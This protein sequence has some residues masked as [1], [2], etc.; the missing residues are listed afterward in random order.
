MPPLPS[1]VRLGVASDQM[2]TI[3]LNDAIRRALEGNNQIEVS[4][5]NVRLAEATLDSL[6]GIYQPVFTITPQI[7]NQAQPLTNVSDVAVGGNLTS[8]STTS[9]TIA[10]GVSKQFRR[11][12]GRYDFSFN[13][14]R[15]T[16]NFNSLSTSYN[17]GFGVNLTQPLLRDRAIDS[18]RRDIRIQRKRLEQ[19]DADFRLQVI[20]IIAQVQNAYWELVFALRDQQNRIANVNLARENFRLT[21]ARVAAGSAAPIAR[22]E[23]QTELS[24]RETELLIASQN[25]SLAENNLKSL[26]LRNTQD[27]AW[28]SQIVPTDEPE[29]D[30]T[31][32]PVSLEAALAAASA[33]RPELRRLRVQQEINEIDVKFF[34]NQTRPRVDLQ[35]NVSTAG[36]A[37]TP[38]INNN[39]GVIPT[40]PPGTPAGQIPLIFGNPQ[41]NS[42]AFLLDQLNQ[43]RAQLNGINGLQLAPVNSPF[44]T[45]Q[46]S[47]VPDNLN[48]GFGRSFRNIFNFDNRN[49]IVGV[50]VELPFRNQTAQANLAG[51][52]ISREQIDAQTRLQEQIVLAEVRNA[53]QA[54]ETARRRV[55]TARTA[56]ESAELQLEGE[57]RLFEAGRSTQFL[58]FQRENAL[59]AARNLELRAETDYNQAQANLQRATSTTLQA[60]NVTVEMPQ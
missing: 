40:L 36:L 16:S 14:S 28:Q 41:T 11:G 48:G 19:S 33:N 55:L 39:F 12:G 34:R 21:E 20:D 17:S 52:R 1:L 6:E 5:T 25:V 9:F 51:A 49:I 15:T 18:F 29:L 44:I 30:T 42:N 3:S 50:R 26:M 54:V 23:V 45:P 59:A 47:R 7:S 24:T 31:D 43:L 38:V 32:A 2:L 58:L 8:I 22:A 37:G 35:A 56:R 53:A 27:A 4:R 46:T 60:N 13:N 10:P 57:R